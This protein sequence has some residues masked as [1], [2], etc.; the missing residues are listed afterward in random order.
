MAKSVAESVKSVS[1]V[2][3]EPNYFVA[4]EE[5]DGF[6]AVLVGTPTCHHDVPID[7]KM[8]FEGADAIG[9]NLKDKKG[10]T[11]WSYGWSGEAPRFFLE[12]VKNRFQ[13]ERYRTCFAHQVRSGPKHA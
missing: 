6:D 11:F 8:L 5:I 12:I 13:N 2:E 4:A 10:T 9:V 3:V 7:I 1:P